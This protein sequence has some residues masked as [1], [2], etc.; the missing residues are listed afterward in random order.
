MLPPTRNW[1]GVLLERRRTI[2]SASSHF[3]LPGKWKRENSSAVIGSH[4]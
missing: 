4:R 1:A 2:P 3:K